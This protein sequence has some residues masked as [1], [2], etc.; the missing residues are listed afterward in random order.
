MTDIE[1]TTEI[2]EIEEA[3]EET[4]PSSFLRIRST[5]PVGPD[6]FASIELEMNPG[7]LDDGGGD[8][9]WLTGF[10]QQIVTAMQEVLVPPVRGRHGM[11]DG[12]TNGR[13]TPGSP[14]PADRSPWAWGAADSG[15]ET[16]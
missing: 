10:C 12:A 9:A 16:H 14:L 4:F 6:Q 8:A 7:Q 1:E 5:Y 11:V 13:R 2:E 3:G 15:S